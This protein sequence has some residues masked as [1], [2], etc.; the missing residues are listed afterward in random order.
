M[1]FPENGTPEQR[2]EYFMDVLKERNAGKTPSIFDDHYD[3]LIRGW[4]SYKVHY[5]VSFPP[6]ATMKV[7]KAQDA[8][9]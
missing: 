6:D 2:F 1:S 7:H 3:E 5:S 4:V 8:Q 9:S